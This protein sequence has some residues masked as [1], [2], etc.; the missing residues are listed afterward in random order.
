MPWGR[1]ASS[2]TLCPVGARQLAWCILLCLRR[3]QGMAG[4]AIVSS[5]M[6]LHI[7]Q[8]FRIG[9][10]LAPTSSPVQRPAFTGMRAGVAA[11]PLPGAVDPTAWMV[12]DAAA[13][14]DIP[15]NLA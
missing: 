7:M 12:F 5:D 15:F 10:M 8:F 4:A 2:N 11:G 13:N 14:H 1:V 9:D 3:R 6:L